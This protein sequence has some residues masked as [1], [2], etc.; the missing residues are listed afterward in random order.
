[1]M[2]IGLTMG[3]IL[4]TMIA[5]VAGLAQLQVKAKSSEASF[6]PSASKEPTKYAYEQFVAYYSVFWMTAFGLVVVTSA[7]EKFD[8]WNYLQLCGGLAL[9]IHLQPII[10]PTAGFSS[11]D[12]NHPLLERYSFKA[13]LWIS[14]YGFI[15]NYWYTQYF[16][17]VLKAKYTMP[18]HRLNNVPIAMFCATHFYFTSYHFFSNAVLRRAETSFKPGFMRSLLF[19]SVIIVFSY[20]TAFL[21]TLSISS[22]P[23]YSFEDRDMAYT[24]GSA[25]YGIYFLVSFPA[26]YFFDRSIDDPKAPIVTLWETVVSSCGYS[27]MILL[28]L[29]F[30]RLYLNIPLLVESGNLFERTD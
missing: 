2:D 12:A 10:F 17:S 29:D 15:G 13:N 9:P 18:A 11:P 25:F 27:M 4:G 24:V 14:I 8:A 5:M 7:Y 1:M 28:C 6:F 21:E 16:Y 22:Y 30:V 23:Y 20:F 26:F 19:V 3:I